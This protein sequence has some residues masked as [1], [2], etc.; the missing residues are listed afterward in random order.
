VKVEQSR[1]GD[2]IQ[3]TNILYFRNYILTQ[4]QTL[5]TN[6]LWLKLRKIFTSGYHVVFSRVCTYPKINLK[7][8][9]RSPTHSENAR[10]NFIGCNKPIKLYLA[11]SLCVGDLFL[12][13]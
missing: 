9:N 13:L 10:Y 7:I 11:F 2:I 4:S 5:E 12:N 8:K 6:T 1:S 3:C